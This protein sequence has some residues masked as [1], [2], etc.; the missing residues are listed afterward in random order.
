[1]TFFLTVLYV[2]HFLASFRSSVATGNTRLVAGFG[3]WEEHIIVSQRYV[4][5][6]QL[7]LESFCLL[8]TLTS[9]PFLLLMCVGAISQTHDLMI[10]KKK[11]GL[12][13]Q[14]RIQIGMRIYV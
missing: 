3:S 14:A 10:S 5:E 8:V 13:H 4:S 6:S 12:N 9:L 11:K 7:S 2:F 1:M